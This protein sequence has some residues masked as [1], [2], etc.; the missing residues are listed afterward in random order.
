MN[1]LYD[2]GASIIRKYISIVD[3]L[4]NGDKLFSVYVHTPTKDRLFNIIEQ[5]CDITS[6]QQICGVIHDTHI[7]LSVKSNKQITSSVV[8]FYNRIRF[9]SILFQVVCDYD[10]FFGMHTLVN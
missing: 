8:D 2:V 10:F 7:P 5:F 9:H 4:S 3:V 6:L 1:A